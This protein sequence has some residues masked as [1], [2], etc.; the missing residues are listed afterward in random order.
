MRASK[1][2]LRKTLAH[3]SAQMSLPLPADFG[4]L[5]VAG[6]TE[7]IGALQSGAAGSDPSPTNPATPA[8]STPPAAST[9][10]KARDAATLATRYA[11]AYRKFHTLPK[12]TAE[13]RALS[14]QLTAVPKFLAQKVTRTSVKVQGEKVFVYSTTKKAYLPLEQTDLRW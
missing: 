1:S 8:P 13:S 3:L 14:A 7:R 4:S 11:E 10:G 9:S 5:T 2:D 6:L 12:G